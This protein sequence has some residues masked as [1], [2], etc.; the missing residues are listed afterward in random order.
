MTWGS[1][2]ASVDQASSYT[3]SLS[4]SIR[5]DLVEEPATVT[6]MLLIQLKM[7]YE[8]GGPKDSLRLMTLITKVVATIP[9]HICRGRMCSNFT[10]HFAWTSAFES[11]KLFQVCDAGEPA[12]RALSKA[13][14]DFFPCWRLMMV[15]VI[16][17]FDPLEGWMRGWCC[18]DDGFE[19]WISGYRKEPWRQI[20]EEKSEVLYK[21]TW[22]S[23]RDESVYNVC[24]VRQQV[25]QL[26]FSA[27]LMGLNRKFMMRGVPICF[28][29]YD[30]A[31]LL[32]S[33]SGRME[34]TGVAETD[35]GW[36]ENL[37]LRR[38]QQNH[39]SK[40]VEG[41]NMKPGW[42]SKTKR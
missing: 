16:N 35:A 26:W 17:G 6:K 23:W 38:W 5:K 37:G 25:Y 14:G 21:L 3:R 1:F 19:E 7:R 8:V 15:M 28:Y 40:R 30:K 31:I 39:A 22:G 9:M 42:R 20:V 27:D 10:R 34:L 12:L 4:R 36:K 32:T 33:K 18:F 41:N 11:N 24:T 2:L 13:E 29:F